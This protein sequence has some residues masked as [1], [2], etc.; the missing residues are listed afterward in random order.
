[1]KQL[2]WEGWV[3]VASGPPDL[4]HTLSGEAPDRTKKLN[5]SE[6]DGLKWL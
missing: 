5:F 3:P 6:R 1:M 2:N 4:T